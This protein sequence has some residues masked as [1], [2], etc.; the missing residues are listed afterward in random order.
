[1]GSRRMVALSGLLIVGL[2]LVACSGS[3]FRNYGHIPFSDAVNRDLEGD[4]VH[5]EMRYF[6]SGSDLYPNALMGL[7]RDYHLS[8][9]ALWK[10]VI[11]TPQKLKEIVG[12]M[13]TKSFAYMQFPY[14][15]DLTDPQGKKI[16]F[17]Y[18]LPAARTSVHFEEDGTVMIPT[19][20]LDTYD[21]L[22][23]PERPNP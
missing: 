21:K 23:P 22:E 4:I 18:S 16:G 13:K 10:E 3:L 12:N 8:R 11:M 20:D 17:W 14:A 19:P 6:I 1:M 2:M 9:G 5:P 7:H 15:F